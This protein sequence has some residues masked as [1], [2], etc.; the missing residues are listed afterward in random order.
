MFNSAKTD[1]VLVRNK[2]YAS[3]NYGS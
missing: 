3:C 1:F 2:S